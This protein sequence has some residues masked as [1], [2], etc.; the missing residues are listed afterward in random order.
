MVLGFRRPAVNDELRMIRRLRPLACALFVLPAACSQDDAAA[1]LACPAGQEPFAGRCVDPAT[2]YEPDERIDHDNVVAYGDP[3]TRLE[4]P[5][6]PKSGFRLVAPP[7][8]LEPGEEIDTCVSWPYPALQNRIIYAA[9]LYTTPGLHHSNMIAKP[10]DPEL[11]PNPY[12]GCH[13]GADDPFSDL[14]EVIPDVLFANSTQVEGGETLA[15]PPGH[16]FVV[17]TSREISTNVHYLNT[18]SEPQVIEVVYD[19]FTMPEAELAKEVAAIA[20]QVNDFLVPPHATETIGAEC[21]L[22]GGEIVSLMPHT[23]QYA[24]RFAVDLV[25][26]GGERSLYEE[27]GFDLE[28]DI[29]VYQP[30]IPTE[31]GDHLRFSC[32]FH[33]TTDH[34]ITYGL[35]DNEM[36]VLFGYVWPPEKQFVAY[37][38]R[39]GDE[40]E[41]FH[42]GLL[43]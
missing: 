6:P 37:A 16:G 39:Q 2:R 38:E 24:Q 29:R 41:S 14:P 5:E 42:I 18:S 23:H 12:P 26:G 36:C 40:C 8:L 15:F 9:R 20:M 32:T 33:N 28:S 1:P 35:G 27:N 22:F 34:D 21:L 11:G 19:Y 25:A 30:A 13:P 10:A 7:R 17:D 4:L 43:R 31:Y 3:L